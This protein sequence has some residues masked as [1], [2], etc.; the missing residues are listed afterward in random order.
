MGIIENGLQ[1]GHIIPDTDNEFEAQ[2]SVYRILE[3]LEKIQIGGDT[4]N[5]P[6]VTSWDSA[7][8]GCVTVPQEKGGQVTLPIVAPHSFK[9]TED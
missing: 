8:F 4:L 6:Y 1:F 2:A 5:R 7:L 9:I 3:S